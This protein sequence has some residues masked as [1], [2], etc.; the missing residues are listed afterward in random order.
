M[1]MYG[2]GLLLLLSIIGFLDAASGFG[3][4]QSVIE[5][6]VKAS[7]LLPYFSVLSIGIALFLCLDGKHDTKW[8]VIFGWVGFL[9]A[10]WMLSEALLLRGEGGYDSAFNWPGYD[11]HLRAGSFVPALV[12]ALASIAVIIRNL[13]GSI[14]QAYLGIAYS[15]LSG[16]IILSIYHFIDPTSAYPFAYLV[17]SPELLNIAIFLLGLSLFFADPTQPILK[18]L[19]AESEL[20]SQFRK[21]LLLLF[22]FPPILMMVLDIF[23]DEGYIN[24]ITGLVTY[25]VSFSVLVLGVIV[26]SLQKIYESKEAEF[27]QLQNLKNLNEKLVFTSSR[28]EEQNQKLTRSNFELTV[29]NERVLRTMEKNAAQNQ[30]IEDLMRQV[31]ELSKRESQEMVENIPLPIIMYRFEP[32][33]P[34]VYANEAACSFSGFSLETITSITIENASPSTWEGGIKQIFE[35]RLSKPDTRNSAIIPFRKKD[36]TLV[37]VLVVSWPYTYNNERVILVCGTELGGQQQ[38]EQQY[39]N[40]SLNLNDLLFEL[41]LNFRFRYVNSIFERFFEIKQED[42][43]G[44]AAFEALPLPVNGPTITAIKKVMETG[45]ASVVEDSYTDSHGLQSWVE[46]TVFKT[47][48]GITCVAR[49]INERVELQQRLRE[50]ER[51]YITLFENS[52]QL[53]FALNEEGYCL[54]CNR[55]ALSYLN[56]PKGEL[57]EAYTIWGLPGLNFDNRSI[58]RIRTNLAKSLLGETLEAFEVSAVNK[59]GKTIF[60]RINLRPIFQDSGLLDFV[61][62]E[63]QDITE[64]EKAWL[65]LRQSEKSLREQSEFTNT[66]IDL[67]PHQIFVYDLVEEK[68]VFFNE[69]LA[70]FFGL[71]IE[72]KTMSAEEAFSPIHPEDIAIGYKLRAD[73]DSDTTDDIYRYVIR[74]RSFKN[75]DFRWFRLAARVLGRDETGKPLQYLAMSSDIQELKEQEQVLVKAK[76]SAEEANLA[77]TNFLANMSHE[78]RNPINAM[79]GVAQLLEKNFSDD[80]KI[81]FYVG[82]LRQ[83]GNRLLTTIGEVLDLSR[84]ESG[85]ATIELTRV[86]INQ[87]LQEVTGTY[88]TLL[89]EKGIGFEVMKLE[90]DI[91]CNLDH[92]LITQVLNNLLTNAVK[93]TVLGMVKV[94]AEV[95]RFNDANKVRIFVSDTGIGMSEEFVQNRLFKAF[96]QESRGFNRKYEGSGLGLHLCQKFVE[97]QNGTIKVQSKKGEGTTFV[98]TFNEFQ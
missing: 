66:I 34:I 65:E 57:T 32:P 82:L 54:Q 16:G 45:E 27:E 97:L 74:Y 87:L 25:T 24:V 49:N 84:I 78:I 38:I 13:R 3:F 42:I 83:S 59:E 20:G 43:K 63:C 61:L 90:T 15:V 14:N 69:K 95:E 51:R 6:R 94:W 12:I 91:Y 22:F 2:T 48:S 5:P 40:L 62:V 17:E 93:F 75:E 35:K 55:R 68:M 29:A 72:Q 70:E 73:I 47:Y 8:P 23:T 60:L 76:A 28:L 89:K 33:F 46:C 67:A 53:T 1:A 21:I 80:G 88:Q 50:K 64:I 81:N 37:E 18:A 44:R 79:L 31:V 10:L 77:K 92:N 71:P 26:L 52:F 30:K 19:A 58:I 56:L 98:I 85:V 96:E 4:F 7:G 86:S 41:D 11:Q 36:G 9:P 39:K